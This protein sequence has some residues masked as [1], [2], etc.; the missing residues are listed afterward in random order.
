METKILGERGTFFSKRKFV[1]I[2]VKTVKL[3]IN[4]ANV[5]PNNQIWGKSLKKKE[6]NEETL[7]SFCSLL[8]LV[9]ETRN[10][11]I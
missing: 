11:K 1:A 4:S 2:F 3:S 10:N 9:K 6:Q 7:E 5:A 8:L